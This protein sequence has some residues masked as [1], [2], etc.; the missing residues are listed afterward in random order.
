M[1]TIFHDPDGQAWTVTIIRDISDQKNIETIWQT[2][3]RS[4]GGS[5][6]TTH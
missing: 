3:T 5:R 1:S 2:A 4:C 6:S